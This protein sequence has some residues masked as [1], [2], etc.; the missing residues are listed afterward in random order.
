MREALTWYV[1]VQVAG[2]A[3]WPLVARA[4]APLDDRG[5]GVAKTAG[6]LSLAW[7]VWLVCM[8]T[9]LPFVRPLLLLAVLGIGTGAWWSAWRV[10]RLADALTWL[11]SRRATLLAWEAVF[12]AA[13]VA[14]ALLRAHDPAI[15]GFEKPMDMAFLN[16]FMLARSLPTQD[17]WLSGYGV[18]YY[19][20]GYFVLACIAKL[21][22]VPAAVAYNLAAATIPALSCVGLGSLA[23][24]LARA[25]LATRLWSSVGASLAVLSG[26]ISGNLSTFFEVLYARGIVP[27]TAGE[28]LGI[29]RFGEGIGST[30]PPENTLWWFKAS[31]VIPNTQPDGINEFP[32]FS[33]LLSDLHPHFVAVPFEILVVSTAAAHVLSRGATLRSWPTQ[34]L[35]ALGLGGLLVINTWDIAPFWTLYVGASLYAV[36]LSGGHSLR[37]WLVA[38]IGPIAGT[39]AYAPYFVGYK[40]PPLGIGIV[41]DHTP[42]GSLLV[43]FGWAIVLV[44]AFG[45]FVRW[46]AGDRRGWL[47]TGAGAVLGSGLALAGQPSI[48]LLVFL[49]ALALPWPRAGHRL[50]PPIVLVAG[51]GAFAVVMLLGSELIYLDD[52]FH[53][54]M[55]TVFKFHVNAWLLSALVGGVGVAVI[56]RSTRRARWLVATLATVFVAAGLVYP[57]SA[58]ATRFRQAPPGGQS[59]DGLL[60]LSPDERAA[61]RWLGDANAA[62]RDRVVITE[63]VGD[64]YS[65]T[66]EMATYSGAT[67]VLGWAGHELQWRGPIPELGIRQGDLASLYR[68]APRESIR[69]LLD[70]Y[71]IAY[72]VVGDQ[73]RKAYGPEVTTRFD[74]LLTAALRTATVTIYRAR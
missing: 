16:G 1:V 25:A 13:F 32:F 35:A 33:A 18:P 54:R 30:W 50:D 38:L 10:D 69:S 19:Y 3:V 28:A 43:L 42:F 72:V 64:E 4:L 46:C 27:A 26:L 59:L 57:F 49:L 37:R 36:S 48:G 21:A 39:V 40:G 31:R 34:G 8:L 51:V 56:G 74:S 44:G 73:E 71:N 68:D 22:D 67:T 63:A 62:A 47:I 15:A 55:N 70:R 12:A 60:F 23:W 20:F 17:A 29:K 9:P 61:I 53:S 41:A 14:F 5:W 11:R 65:S 7:V 2:V 66:A 24:N 58:F 6:V 52:V 45:L